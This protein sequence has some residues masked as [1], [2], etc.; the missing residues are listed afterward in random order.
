MSYRQEAR[1]TVERGAEIVVIALLRMARMY[2]HTNA[3]REQ[4]V[5][6]KAYPNVLLL[7]GGLC[8]HCRQHRTA[9]SLE[10]HAERITQGFED[11]PMMPSDRLA[12]QH[13]VLLQ[14]DA[15][16][17]GM[18]LPEFGAAFDIGKE[19]RHRSAG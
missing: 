10:N 5:V 14:G 9:C 17:F 15:H 13:I 2:G 1:H 12:H 7:E 18:L 19:E 3:Q 11:M 8:L 4:F 6:R 16:G